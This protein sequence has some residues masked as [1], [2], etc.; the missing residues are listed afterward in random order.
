VQHFDFENEDVF[1]TI[2]NN[3]KTFAQLAAWEFHAF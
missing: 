1:R 3:A 2:E